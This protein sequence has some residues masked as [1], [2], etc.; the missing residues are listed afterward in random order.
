MW[1]WPYALGSLPGQRASLKST[2][3]H[4][5]WV[6]EYFLKRLISATQICH[7]FALLHSI[8]RRKTFIIMSMYVIFFKNDI[9]YIMLII[10]YICSRRQKITFILIHVN[11]TAWIQ[12][13]PAGSWSNLF[14]PIWGFQFLYMFSAEGSSHGIE[15]CSNSAGWN[16]WLNTHIFNTQCSEVNLQSVVLNLRLLGAQTDVWTLYLQAQDCTFALQLC[17]MVISLACSMIVLEGE[18]TLQIPFGSS[19]VTEVPTPEVNHMNL[20]RFAT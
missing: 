4:G 6:T 15:F 5:N 18:E 12:M 2:S 16:E 10:S 13:N 11:H 3:L 1:S 7:T 8:I 20:I 9:K 14:I 19:E 17:W